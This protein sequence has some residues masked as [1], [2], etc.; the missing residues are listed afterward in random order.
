MGKRQKGAALF[1]DQSRLLIP[2]NSSFR[3][4]GSLDNERALCMIA[5]A[6]DLNVFAPSIAA[7][8]TAILLAV[9]NITKAR[10]VRAFVVFQVRH[11]N[12][13]E[14]GCSDFST[15]TF[16]AG[17]SYRPGIN[18]FDPSLT[19]NASHHESEIS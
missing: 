9:S 3:W 10:D 7:S 1:L 18:N 16:G 4:R 2:M 11:G 5:L 12:S 8:V 17:F 13:S 15:A 6:G 14:Y 19:K